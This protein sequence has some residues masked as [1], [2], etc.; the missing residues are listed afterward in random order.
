MELDFIKFEDKK[1]DW[2]I[3]IEFEKEKEDLKNIWFWLRLYCVF[4]LILIV[5]IYRNYL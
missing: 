1:F 5:K 3:D 2:W 4:I